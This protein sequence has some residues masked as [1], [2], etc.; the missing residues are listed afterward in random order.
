MPWAIDTVQGIIESSTIIR[1]ARLSAFLIVAGTL[2]T[3]VPAGAA[4]EEAGRMMLVLDSSGSMKEKAASGVTKISAAREAL[5]TVIDGL[6]EGQDVGLRVYGAKVFSRD[7]KGACTDS[8]RV[9][10]PATDNRA[11]LK[12]AIATYK[13]FGETPT[14]Y[15]L[16]QAGKDLG[17]DGQ[18]TIVLV[19]D[20]EPTCTPD[21]CKVAA[22]LAK[23]GID[24]RI[25]V[26]GLD[27]SGKAREDLRCVAAAGSGTYYD[28]GDADE[29]SSALQTLASRARLPYSVV[30]KKITGAQSKADAPKITPGDW[31]DT[32]G[33]VSS[34]ERERY[35][36]LD[37]FDPTSTL[38]IS[39][40]ILQSKADKDAIQ[41][42]V[43]NATAK[44]GFDACVRDWDLDLGQFRPAGMLTASVNLSRP[45]DVNDENCAGRLYLRVSRSMGAGGGKDAA[46][47][48]SA[49]NDLP[50]EIRIIEEPAVKTPDLLPARAEDSAVVF[51]KMTPGPDPTEL[52]PGTSF[53]NAPTIKPG[54]FTGNVVP[55][56]AQIVYVDVDWG[57]R[58]Q[59]QLEYPEIDTKKYGNLSIDSRLDVYSPARAKSDKLLPNNDLGG[60]SQIQNSA[61]IGNNSYS[62]MYATTLPVAYNNRQTPVG[63][64]EH[65][66]GPSL[67]G[68]YALV[69]QTG[70][71]NNTNASL[72]I[73]YTMELAVVGELSGKPTYV[74]KPKAVGEGGSAKLKASAEDDDPGLP[75]LRVGLG[76]AGIAALA[77]AF[78]LF[79]R[80]RHS[81]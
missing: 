63:A 21:P 31:A 5:G 45:K 24:L 20:G 9:V 81:T 59:V 47:G 16:Q 34:V 71:A 26:V 77:G 18:R 50:V 74:S 8:Q 33:K 13:P 51:T 17:K 67:A 61:I 48:S 75:L 42:Q 65:D 55:G 11:Q 7:D 15:A 12:R 64:A 49:D 72:Q 79:R 38:H 1:I 39:A 66:S 52:V 41:I 57:Q 44:D 6:P 3:P 78:V 80:S 70:R 69:L 14:G 23:N 46:L 60:S 27:V 19:S 53:G 4:G 73:P 58:L 62:T 30:G 76:V 35:Y 40:S 10:D 29:L 28:A 32:I 22:D 43:L 68:K 36:R 2:L 25:D 37:G 54:S 56:E